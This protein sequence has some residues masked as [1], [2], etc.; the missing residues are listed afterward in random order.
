VIPPSS[1][2]NQPERTASISERVTVGGKLAANALMTLIDVNPKKTSLIQS[3]GRAS[4]DGH[5]YKA[6]TDADGSRHFTGLPAGEYKA[7][8][9]SD[10]YVPANRA[11]GEAGT[12]QL[13]P[14]AENLKN[15]VELQPCQRINDHVLREK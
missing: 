6:T 12:I 13:T 5:G 8:S 3:N 4:V 15:A 2:E 14:D 11:R 10:A 7:T 9:L 1:S